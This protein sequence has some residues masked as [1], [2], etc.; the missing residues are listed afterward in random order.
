M[1]LIAEFRDIEFTP[2]IMDRLWQNNVK[3]YPVEQHAIHK[4]RH[5]NKVILG[6]GNLGEREIITWLE[7]THHFPANVG[8]CGRTSSP[9][10]SITSSH[11]R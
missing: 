10:S 7:D 2:E 9:N 5:R 1:H 3:V 4:G 6:Y 8:K 11:G